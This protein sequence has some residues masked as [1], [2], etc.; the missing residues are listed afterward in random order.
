MNIKPRTQILF[1][2]GMMAAA[3]IVFL[4]EFYYAKTHP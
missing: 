1:I 4:L 3:Y 2:A